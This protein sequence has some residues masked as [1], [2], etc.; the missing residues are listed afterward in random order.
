VKNGL[1]GFLVH[2]FARPNRQRKKRIPPDGRFS[3]RKSTE[4]LK[5][6]RNQLYYILVKLPKIGKF[7]PCRNSPRTFRT[8]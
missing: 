2:F 4:S 3:E 7:V 1:Q 5:E 6:G 8:I